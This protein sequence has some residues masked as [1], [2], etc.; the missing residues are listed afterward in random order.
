LIPKKI[1]YIWFGGKPLS[2]LHLRCI[3]SWKRFAPDFEIIR[4]DETNCDVYGTPYTTHCCKEKAWAFVA[5]YFRFKILGE[6]GGVYM[7]TDT[8]L[9][10]PLD[11]LLSH[12][13]FFAFESRKQL[14][15]AVV[16]SVPGHFTVKQIADLYRGDAFKN[17]KGQII[18]VSVPF[19]V[20]KILK[21]HGLN[22]NGKMQILDGDIAI[23]PANI[24]TF[25]ARDGECIADHYYEFT[26]YTPGVHGGGNKPKMSTANYAMKEYFR[27]LYLDE[28]NIKRR[29][30]RAAKRVLKSLRI[31]K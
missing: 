14:N 11:S 23:Y 28:N 15:A 22:P 9:K 18:S 3:D 10:A 25:D 30:K 2:E 4:W 13:A 24:L 26:W 17:E 5:D 31:I 21:K 1:H 8:E 7:D 12:N 29:L 27:M 19:T 16:G 20:T 6:H